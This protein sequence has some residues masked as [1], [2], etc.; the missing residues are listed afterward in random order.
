MYRKI[1][2][3]RTQKNELCKATRQHVVDLVEGEHTRGFDAL[4]RRS[5]KKQNLIRR[6]VAAS[7][8]QKL[9]HPWTADDSTAPFKTAATAAL[10][11][12]P[13]SGQSRL[14]T[15]SA[16][17]TTELGLDHA[18]ADLIHSCALPFSLSEEPKF[19][20]IVKLAKFV[21]TRYVSPSR[22]AIGGEL[23]DSNYKCVMEKQ[24][25]VLV[26]EAKSYGI[27]LFGDA[28]TIHKIPYVN[29]LASTPSLPAACLEI[30]DCTEQMGEGGTKDA[31]H[32]SST[33]LPH[34]LRLDPDKE[35][36]DQVTFDGGTNFQKAARAV[37]VLYPL[38]TVTH[39]VEHVVA[40]FFKDVLGGSSVL[41]LLVR[42]YR[43]L[44]WIF[45][46]SHHG[47]HA[48]FKKHAKAHNDGILIGLL[49][50]SDVRMA[51][52]IY[53]FLRLLRLRPAFDATMASPEYPGYKVD[54]RI[55]KVL[56]NDTYWNITQLV[57]KA[58]FG[59]LHLLRI[60]DKKNPCSDKVFFLHSE[61]RSLHQ[62]VQSRPQRF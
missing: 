28:A 43:L 59:P 53:A 11:K 56:K 35:L 42:F 25:A 14:T 47:I 40:L 44:C 4:S 34:M 33:M 26:Q 38:V 36:F 21:S 5:G 51:G 9:H 2:E 62:E 54:G 41:K 32:V 45:G 6:N 46:G 3:I 39:G 58:S 23:L 27:V 12:L 7:K 19:R 48:C 37:E 30:H 29:L 24:D 55:T 57:V 31:A 17:P 15:D 50:P 16:N 22:H 52:F 61:S 18:I 20:K 13:R 60:A 8:K 49:R 1:F 10:S